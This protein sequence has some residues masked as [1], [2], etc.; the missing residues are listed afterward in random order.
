MALWA[1]LKGTTQATYNI[2]GHI[3]KAITGGLA[4]RN[5]ADSA[6]EKVQASQFEAN[7]D[8]GLIVNADAAGT[9][10]DWKITLQRPTSG[11]TAN[12][13]LTFPIDDGTPSQVLSTDGS[14]VLSWVSAGSTAPNIA[15]DTTNLAFNSGTTVTLFSTP[16]NAI[17]NK[18]QVVID[19]AFNGTP[20][21]TVG[22]SGT[23]AKYMGSGQ[24]NLNGTAGDIYESNPGLAAT[25]GEALIA[26]YSAGGASAGAA[27]IL[28]WY[29]VPS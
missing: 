4:F 11:M 21:V 25:A 12:Y 15:V 5:A 24:N 20:T 10:A 14:G 28:V 19:T 2:G 6:D 9:G 7:G 18:V 8:I 27:R 1:D 13:T 29:E 17:I 16:A 22:I 23:T 26:T 3:L